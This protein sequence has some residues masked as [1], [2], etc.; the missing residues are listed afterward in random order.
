MDPPK[1]GHCNII[2]ISN[3]DTASNATLS[4][5]IA[6]RTS[7]KGRSIFIGPNISVVPNVSLV[8]R[9]HCLNFIN[10]VCIVCVFVFVWKRR[11]RGLLSVGSGEGI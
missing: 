9:F 2:D 7:K 11:Q 6:L 8:W 10:V 4:L 1:W 3:K 5:S